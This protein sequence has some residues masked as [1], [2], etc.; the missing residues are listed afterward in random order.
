MIYKW[1]RVSHRNDKPSEMTLDTVRSP[2]GNLCG[3]SSWRL[4]DIGQHPNAWSY[5]H[6]AP[7]GNS[8]L[9]V[10]AW[11][12]SLQIMFDDNDGIVGWSVAPIHMVT[13]LTALRHMMS[14]HFCSLNPENL[15][16]V[17]M[18]R[19][20]SRQLHK[21][22]TTWRHRHTLNVYMRNSDHKHTRTFIFGQAYMK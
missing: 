2:L 7:T 21:S 16:A 3:S 6:S 5:A 10:W 22:T 19:F 12:Q 1:R 15:M 9:L 13:R 4:H 14:T 20:M 18:T 8:K 11:I 17:D